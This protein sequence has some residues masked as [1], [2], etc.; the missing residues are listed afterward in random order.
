MQGE[1]PSVRS[2]TWTV[3]TALFCSTIS[4]SSLI[5]QTHLF[6]MPFILSTLI[7]I[8]LF[9]FFFYELFVGS[10]DAELS[11]VLP[12]FTV[13]LFNFLHKLSTIVRSFGFPFKSTIICDVH[14]HRCLGYVYSR[15]HLVFRCESF[16]SHLVAVVRVST[17]TNRNIYNHTH[18]HCLQCPLSGELWQRLLISCRF[19]FAALLPCF[20]FFSSVDWMMAIHLGCYFITM[21]LK[22]LFVRHFLC[23]GISGISFYSL[24]STELAPI[25]V[26]GTLVVH[27]CC[28]HTHTHQIRRNSHGQVYFLS[29]KL[30]VCEAMWWNKS[31]HTF[32]E[33][34]HQQ[35]T[36]IIETE[37]YKYMRISMRKRWSIPCLPCS[38][39]CLAIYCVLPVGYIPH[40]KPC[41][42][43][44]LSHSADVLSCCTQ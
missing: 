16:C 43:F 26:T 28:A 37:E 33:S 17:S 27:S 3:H 13:F 19:P 14:W 30:F 36:G 12:F 35:Y 42:P 31:I 38:F 11:Y 25:L 40:E 41:V 2:K 32:S 6:P 18:Q 9:F 15:D 5:N 8:P 10:A 20:P 24:R 7:L 23:V 4:C 29:L 44:S 21:S 39:I 34:E 22:K 1:Q